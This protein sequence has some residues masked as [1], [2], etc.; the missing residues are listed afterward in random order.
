MMEK[1]LYV[2]T[3]KKGKT[4]N[5]VTK[6]V[7]IRHVENL[8]K[9][10]EEGKIELCGPFKGYPGVAGMVIF[11][12]ATYEEAGELCKQEPLVAEGFASY[13]LASLQVADRDNNYLL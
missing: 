7:I 2:M 3:I 12:T 6:A 10:D 4:F 11:K 1:W 9:L 13:V 8:R 5:K